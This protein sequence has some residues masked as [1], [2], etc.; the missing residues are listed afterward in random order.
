MA[1]K[2]NLLVGIRHIILTIL[3]SSS[4]IALIVFAI[5]TSARILWQ[6]IK[7]LATED[8]QV[9]CDLESQLQRVTLL[10]FCYRSMLTPKEHNYYDN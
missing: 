6:K 2:H 4:F 9:L 7:N 1:E 8:E 5:I 3:R 10:T